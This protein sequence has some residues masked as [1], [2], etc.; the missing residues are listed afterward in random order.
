M[1]WR[2]SRSSLNYKEDARR[3]TYYSCAY[4]CIYIY[5]NICIYIYIYTYTY[6]QTCIYIH[7]NIYVYTYIYIFIYIYV[8]VCIYI[9]IYIYM[10][11]CVCVCGVYIIVSICICTY[12]IY[13][14]IYVCIHTYIYIYIYIYIYMYILWRR[15]YRYTSLA[16]VWGTEIT[17]W[18]FSYLG[19]MLKK[20]TGKGV[21]TKIH[22]VGRGI[23]LSGL[24]LSYLPG[25]YFLVSF[26]VRRDWLW[27][28]ARMAGHRSANGI[29][30]ATFRVLGDF[31]RDALTGIPL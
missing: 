27:R 29:E 3:R 1:G 18:L 28:S 17:I 6:K 21:S 26:V 13:L 7:I 23:L 30:P 11:M 20:Y 4:I 10:Y 24:I 14:Y 8:Y 2:T 16:W 5:V 15:P 22:S 25:A 12:N 9:Y 31:W 19:P